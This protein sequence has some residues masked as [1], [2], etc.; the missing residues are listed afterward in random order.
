MDKPEKVIMI[1]DQ[2]DKDIAPAQEAGLIG[3]YYPG[4]FMPTWIT[5]RPE[6]SPDYEIKSFDE[7]VIGIIERL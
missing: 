6:I 2:L 1:G 7:K 5:N 3:V 4:G